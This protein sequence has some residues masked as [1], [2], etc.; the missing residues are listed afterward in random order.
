MI[1]ARNPHANLD[2]V[3]EM[4]EIFFQFALKCWARSPPTFYINQPDVHLL[5]RSTA[6][7]LIYNLH[8][9]NSALL[10]ILS[11]GLDYGQLNV[12]KVKE[13]CRARS[14]LEF[15]TTDL[16]KIPIERRKISIALVHI[17]DDPML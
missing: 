7:S 8:I 10:R 6:D 12:K 16:A 17:S 15:V 11:N 9:Y 2:L 4:F 14:G 1:L 5:L 3:F 13:I